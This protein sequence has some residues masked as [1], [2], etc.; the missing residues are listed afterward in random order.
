LSGRLPD[1]YFDRIYADSDDPWQFGARW[2]EQRKYAITVAVLPFRR[3]RHAF[4][5][6][7]SVGVLTEAL[8]QRCDRV[9]ATDVSTA[10]LDATYRRLSAARLTDRVHLVR[11]SLDEPWP[12]VP[13]DLVVLSEL[14]YYLE[15]ETLR[16]VLDREVPRLG[17]PATLV[18]AHWR[19]A[20]E[21]YPMSGD[22]ANEIIGQTA[23]LHRLGGYL[24]DDVVIDV[25]DT[26]SAQS[27]AERTSVPGA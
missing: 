17:R 8:A 7:C 27:V 15:P 1:A 2:Y 21:D 12:A 25:F 18:A 10:A 3:Y 9:T 6:G 16:Q 24:D 26:A 13:F 20:V 23:G 22:Q 14:C 19:H 4:E 11:R 5:P